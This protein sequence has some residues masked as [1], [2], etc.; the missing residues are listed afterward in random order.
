M[1]YLVDVNYEDGEDH[2]Y[3]F[4]TYEE[5]LEFAKGLKGDD[6]GIYKAVSYMDEFGN[7]REA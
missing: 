3:Y 1:I 5:A 2:N 6:C 4:E 7:L